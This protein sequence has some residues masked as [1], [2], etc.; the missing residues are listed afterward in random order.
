[1]TYGKSVSGYCI[2]FIKRLDEG[3]KL[4]LLEQKLSFLRVYAFKFVDKNLIE[5]TQARWSSMP[6]F[7]VV[8]YCCAR[9]MNA[10]CENA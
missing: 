9:V 10:A 4:Q 2:A 5:G 3:L 6:I 8:R 1:M 7:I